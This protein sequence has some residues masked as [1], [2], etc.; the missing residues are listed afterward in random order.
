MVR[1]GTP[2]PPFTSPVAIS[3]TVGACANWPAREPSG[4]R[5]L[6]LGFR[7]TTATSTLPLP[8]AFTGPGGPLGGGGAPLENDGAPRPSGSAA[9]AEAVP[10]ILASGSGMSAVCTGITARG[11]RWL[12][13]GG[14]NA[15]RGFGISTGCVLICSALFTSPVGV[16]GDMFG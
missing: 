7:P 8:A 14:T 10:E 6:S 9:R 16:G 13:G 2:K 3:P 12:G 1:F 11:G 5:P 4:P 15:L